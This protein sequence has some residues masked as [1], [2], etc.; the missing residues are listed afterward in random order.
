[1]TDARRRWVRPAAALV[2]VTGSVALAAPASAEPPPGARSNLGLCSPFLAG[3][4]AP[5]DPV[6][7]EVL[8]G[9]ARSGVNQLIIRYGELQPDALQNPGDLYKIRAREHPTDSAA[10]ECLPRRQP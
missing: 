2:L 8:G 10:E 9:N 3:L 7:G 1:M 6:T 4:P 5:T